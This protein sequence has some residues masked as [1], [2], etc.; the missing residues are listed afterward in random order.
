MQRD[1]DTHPDAAVVA[2]VAALDTV[3][4]GKHFLDQLGIV[5]FQR[6]ERL[7]VHFRG[8]ACAAKQVGGDAAHVDDGALPVDKVDAVVEAERAEVAR[9]LQLAAHAHLLQ[10]DHGLAEMAVAPPLPLVGDHVGLDQ[11]GAD[12]APFT[13]MDREHILDD[14]RAVAQHLALP[15]PA[16]AAAQRLEQ[17]RLLLERHLAPDGVLAIER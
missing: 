9:T 14:R 6:G 4:R 15:P 13:S 16:G 12:H 5:A 2:L 7:L 1:G 17:Q 11:H 8:D 10:P 3:V